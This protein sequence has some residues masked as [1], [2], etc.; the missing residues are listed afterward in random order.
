[1]SQ[2][3]PH[4]G[5]IIP[6]YTVG[7]SLESSCRYVD[8]FC[9]SR[10]GVTPGLQDHFHT[11]VWCKTRL[12]GPPLLP[13][14]KLVNPTTPSWEFPGIVP[15]NSW[16]TAGPLPWYHTRTRGPPSR[17]LL[18]LLSTP[19]ALLG[20]TRLPGIRIPRNFSERP[21]L[22]HP[23]PKVYKRYAFKRQNTPHITVS[24]REQ[25]ISQCL[26]G[27][28]IRTKPVVKVYIC[29]CA[30]HIDKSQITHSVLV[31]QRTVY[32]HWHCAF[33]FQRTVFFSALTKEKA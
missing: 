11:S 18:G 8:H 31:F 27:S 33:R 2:T 28:H 15:R 12:P 16:N 25:F 9:P 22:Y 6:S 30:R 14:G 20:K 32:C 7:N 24:F 26:V 3:S 29:V 1:M 21:L 19:V 4:S 17:V 23:V 5:G 10:P 13:S